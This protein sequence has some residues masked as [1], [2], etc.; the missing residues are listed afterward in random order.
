[1][2]YAVLDARGECYAIE[3]T[4]GGAVIR[5]IDATDFLREAAECGHPAA[6]RWVAQRLPLRVEEIGEE[7]ASELREEGTPVLER[8]P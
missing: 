3:E 8:E 5:Q 6:P 1:M 7:Q 4:R 2:K